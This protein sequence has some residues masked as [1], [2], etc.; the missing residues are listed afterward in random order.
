MIPLLFSESCRNLGFFSYCLR[1]LSKK[2]CLIYLYHFKKFWSGIF[3]ILSRGFFFVF[4]LI[5]IYLL[6]YLNSSNHSSSIV[7]TSSKVI[8]NF[9]S[10]K[11]LH[12]S[13]PSINSIGSAPGLDASFF[14]LLVK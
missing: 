12:I 9:N 4:F 7:T 8:P 3:Q 11:R 1:L 6:T 10:L 14:A 13:T 5:K 2:C